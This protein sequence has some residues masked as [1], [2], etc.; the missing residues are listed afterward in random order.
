[1]S[2]EELVQTLRQKVRAHSSRPVSCPP[3][4]EAW[5]RLQA[6]S[7]FMSLF[8][9]LCATFGL[10]FRGVLLQPDAG[11]EGVR[12]GRLTC[13]VAGVASGRDAGVDQA[14]VVRPN[15]LAAH[16]DLV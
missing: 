1:M 5:R 3:R 7:R 11:L 8:G 14:A 16:L 6:S 15:A 12:S 2:F 9:D 10:P 4:E 13:A